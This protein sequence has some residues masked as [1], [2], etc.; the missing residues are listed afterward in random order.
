M[1][2]SLPSNIDS[3][4]LKISGEI[5]AIAAAY[6]QLAVTVQT[7]AKRIEDLENKYEPKEENE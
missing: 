6:K 5:S 1:N 4:A 7:Q 2:N 3:E